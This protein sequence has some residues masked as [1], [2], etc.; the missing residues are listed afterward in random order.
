MPVETTVAAMGA[1]DVEIGLVAA[2]YGPQGVLISNDE[3]AEFVAEPG[4]RLRGVAG[5]GRTRRPGQAVRELR[6]AVE[7]LGFVALRIVPRLRRLPPTDR[8]YHPLYAACVELDTPFGTQV[9][10]TGPVRPSETGRP[11]H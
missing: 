8:L 3:L 2:W 5:A 7:Q 1:A 4:G 9:G 11:I 6:R 10:H